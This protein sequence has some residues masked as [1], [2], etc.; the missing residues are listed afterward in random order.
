MVVSAP[1]ATDPELKGVTGNTDDWEED[2]EEALFSAKGVIPNPEGVPGESTEGVLFPQG[3]ARSVN[4]ESILEWAK[5]WKVE[6][7]LKPALPDAATGCAGTTMSPRD[8]V[9]RSRDTVP[10]LGCTKAAVP[11]CRDCECC[12]SCCRCA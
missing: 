5:G 12:S 6:V 9:G 7:G 3:V 2:V 4:R 10:S 1:E 8:K 11:P